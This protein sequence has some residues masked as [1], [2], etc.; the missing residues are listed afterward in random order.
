[1]DVY[2]ELCPY[3]ERSRAARCSSCV[4]KADGSPPCVLNWLRM[5]MEVMVNRTREDYRKAA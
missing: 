2:T 1:M 4:K 3:E 5:R